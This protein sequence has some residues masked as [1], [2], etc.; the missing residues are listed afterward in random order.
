MLEARD[1]SVSYGQIRVLYGIDVTIGD[2]EIVAL[3]GPNGAGKTSTLN[4]L[5]GLLPRDGEVT[6]DGEELPPVAEEVVRRGLA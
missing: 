2:G 3:I 6:L 5:A 1:L 4:A